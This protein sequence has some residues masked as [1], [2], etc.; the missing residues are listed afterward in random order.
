MKLSVVIRW[1][2]LI[3]LICWAGWLIVDRWSGVPAKQ[4]T[5]LALGELLSSIP[6]D[7]SMDRTAELLKAMD[8]FPPPVPLNIP[9]AP[10][11]MKWFMV[12][13]Q[14]EA[15]TSLSGE[16]TPEKRPN[17]VALATYFEDSETKAAFELLSTIQSGGFRDPHDNHVRS[18][19]QRYRELIRMCMARARYYHAQVSDLDTAIDDLR[20]A[21]ALSSL[22]YQ[23]GVF[24]SILCG[25]TDA[26]WVAAELQ[27]LSQEQGLSAYHVNR[28]ADAFKK[29]IPGIEESY[30]L[31]VQSI[32]ANKR[33]I[34]DYAYTDDGQ[35]DGWLVLAAFDHVGSG[36]L[37]TEYRSGSWNALSF[38]YNGRTTVMAKIAA[39]EAKYQRAIELPFHDSVRMLRDEQNTVELNVLDG[40]AYSS[41]WFDRTVVRNYRNQFEIS[42]AIVAAALSAYRTQHGHYPS[43]LSDLQPEILAE[44][45]RDPFGTGPLCYQLE[46]DN[47][48][49]L[50]SVGYN[51]VDDGGAKYQHN[52]DI[53]LSQGDLLMRQERSKLWGET[54]LVEDE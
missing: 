44:I 34:V 43:Q 41:T 32:M 48:F 16:W 18:F 46:P 22:A 36:T 27:L 13:Q 9:P 47:T 7:P 29:H 50:Y 23:S 28:I 54:H 45:P 17:L 6:I 20:T 10:E 51:G 12:N 14:M 53:L 33:Q 40:P 25:E 39:E 37:A 30:L 5:L 15:R 26:Q 35:G 1:C 52:A 31:S 3:A 38:L 2:L 11:R 21:L 8:A 49:I 42:S 4:T 24:F 19:P